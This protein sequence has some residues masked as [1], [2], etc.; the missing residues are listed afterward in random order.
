[1][2]IVIQHVANYAPWIYAICGLVAL[3]Q[4]YR[5]WLV[6]NER[7]QAVFSLER[8]KAI[9]DTYSIFGVALVL[10]LVMGFTYFVSTTLA[11]AVQPLISEALQPTPSLPFGI[12]TPTNTP[13]AVMPTPTWTPTPAPD[14]PPEDAEVGETPSPPAE[15]QTEADDPLAAAQTATV[16]AAEIPPTPEPTATPAPVVAPT[17]ADSRAVLFRPGQNE[18]VHGVVNIIGRATH[19]NF[20]YYKLEYAPGAN[21]GGGFAYLT[22]GDSPVENGVLASIDTHTLGNGEWTLQ[23]VVVDQT[24]N[25]PPPCQV[26]ITVQN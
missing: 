8:E 16:V 23:L 1:M 12:P 9:H 3:Y 15:G 17:C 26:T 21:A 22:G 20:Q 11:A 4:I 19:E 7:K 6:R 2:G 13:S 14:A 24:G 5:I 18:V 25:W 10:L